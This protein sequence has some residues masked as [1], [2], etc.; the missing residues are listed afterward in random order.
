[1]RMRVLHGRIG[2]GQKDAGVAAL[3]FVGGVVLLHS[4]A[5]SAR[6]SGTA[7][8]V[9]EYGYPAPALIGTLAAVC[10]A[11]ALRRRAPVAGLVI[12]TIGF[13]A[14][15]VMGAALGTILI[16]TDNLYA[17]CIYGPRKLSRILPALSATLTIALG[18]AVFAT[19]QQLSASIVLMVVIAM[20]L[21][22]PVATATVVKQH[23]D[24]AETER[25]HADQVVRLAELDRRE[26]VNAERTRMAR[27]LHDVIANHLGIVVLQ[28][29][30]V[31]AR[32]DLDAE[33]VRRLL[34]TIRENGVQG[35]T[36]MGAFIDLLRDDT[37]GEGLP[38]TS[39]RISEL[40]RL[41]EQAG[42]QAHL[43]TI[44]EPRPLPATVELAAYRITQ[45]SVTNALKHGG[46]GPIG[47]QLRYRE[48][49][50]DLTI[51]NELNGSATPELPGCGAG[52]TGM[53]ERAALL[54]GR[55]T[56]GSSGHGWRIHVVLPTSTRTVA[57]G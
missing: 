20:V 32:P 31:L 21:V 29:T 50:I 28:S 18:V 23:R 34:T 44:G 15:V 24:R 14:D 26:A 11:V 19:G 33:T 52:L 43:E 51:D 25:L 36:E 41:I 47:V 16:Y 13:V 37:A 45:E 3:L 39:T 35:L 4:G 57:D 6:D 7:W 27:E 48:G 5:Y 46:D 40:G 17:A 56:A 22:T 1:M 2:G 42:E 54:G 9:T 12:G 30:A 55:L 53:R 38:S 8:S 49:E 10:A